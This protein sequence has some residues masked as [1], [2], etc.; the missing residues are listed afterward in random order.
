M[1]ASYSIAKLLIEFINTQMALDDF[2]KKENELNSQNVFQPVSDLIKDELLH[3]QTHA[4]EWSKRN[5]RSNFY[6]D[7]EGYPFT[8]PN[9]E[10]FLKYVKENNITKKQL[11]GVYLDVVKAPLEADLRLNGS[12][13]TFY[14][15]LTKEI[16]TNEQLALHVLS[17]L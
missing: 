4:D 7:L 13:L 9:E 2:L 3:E 6:R 12:D 15:I 14:K 17:D 8:A 5:I 16:K 11:L 10:D 1:S